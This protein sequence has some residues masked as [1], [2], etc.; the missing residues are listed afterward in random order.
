MIQY[1]AAS[2]IEL[3]QRGVLNAR[4]RGHDDIQVLV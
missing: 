1:S 3:K 2:V 4:L